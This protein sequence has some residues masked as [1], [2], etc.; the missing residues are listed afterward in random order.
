MIISK[1]IYIQ[2]LSS[3]NQDNHY[4]ILEKLINYYKII[5]MTR[6]NIYDPYTFAEELK[7]YFDE[8]IE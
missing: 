8:K 4:D 6:T 3:N 1:N 5:K 2:F 7:S